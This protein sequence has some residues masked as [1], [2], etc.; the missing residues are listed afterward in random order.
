ML[1]LLVARLIVNRR[2]ELVEHSPDG[3]RP[4][5][6]MRDWDRRLSHPWLPISF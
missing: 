2:A 4:Q 6:Q 3:P 5:F 1:W